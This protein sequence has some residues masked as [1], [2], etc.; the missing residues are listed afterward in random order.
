MVSF[1]RLNRILISFALTAAVL[2]SFA[3]MASATTF[4]ELIATPITIKKDGVTIHGFRYSRPGSP[5]DPTKPWMLFPHGLTSNLHEFESLIPKFADE[6]FD[7]FAFNFRGHGNG[8]ERSTVD[9]Y[10]EGDYRF[11]KMADVDLPLM[12]ETIQSLHPGPG[13]LIG[14]SMGGMVPRAA[15]YRGTVTAREI[16]SMVLIGSPAHFKTAAAKTDHFGLQWHLKN[17]LF[18]GSGKEPVLN[19]ERARAAMKLTMFLGPLAW[20][21]KSLIGSS[22]KSLME[23]EL[24]PLALLPTKENWSQRAMSDLTPK[25]IFRSFAEFQESYPYDSVPIPVPILHIVGDQD[26]LAPANDI[27]ESAQTQSAD[28]GFWAIRVKEMGHFG[29]VAPWVIDGY[30]PSVLN[31]IKSPKRLGPKNRVILSYSPHE[32]S[33]PA[34]TCEGLF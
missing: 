15:F 7:C 2:A 28:A 13:Q 17:Y 26:T 30:L 19:M 12:I 24:G 4:D 22:I 3:A 18:F 25:D 29:L 8:P 23:K 31:F 10:S 6:G 21:G 16:S 5:H 1:A 20:A 32:I 33:G 27:I 34:G 9:H 11:E 14:H